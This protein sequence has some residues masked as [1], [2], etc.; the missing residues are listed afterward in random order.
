[1]GYN[2]ASRHERGYGYQW[3]KLRK[4]V[5]L[6]DFYLCQ[7]CREDDRLTPA[8]EVDHITPKVLDG[9][10]DLSNLQAICRECHEAKTKREE[11]ARRNGRVTFDADGWPV[12]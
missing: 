6:R 11:D 4:Q 7:P 5:M 1:M 2:A 3:E 9:Q 12:W 8:T 10:D